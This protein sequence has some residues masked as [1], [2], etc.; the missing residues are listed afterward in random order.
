LSDSAI[1]LSGLGVLVALVLGAV[2][3]IVSALGASRR[4]DDRPARTAPSDLLGAP[5][6]SV[7]GS[8]IDASR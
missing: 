3:G 1:A 2:T 4:R 8:S 5:T 6:A 7:Q